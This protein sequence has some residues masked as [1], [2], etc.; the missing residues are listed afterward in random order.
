MASSLIATFCGDKS[1]RSFSVRSLQ[2]SPK[3]VSP[4]LGPD[5][6]SFD[7]IVVVLQDSGIPGSYFMK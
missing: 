5:Q 3:A 2:A 6:L 7:S 4:G 1:L